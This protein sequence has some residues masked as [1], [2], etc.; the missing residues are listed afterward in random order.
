MDNTTQTLTI[1]TA[2]TVAT[3]S[4]LTIGG[5]VLTNAVIA[6]SGQATFTLTGG[7]TS[8]QTITSNAELAAAVQLLQAND[9]GAAGDSVFFTGTISGVSSTFIYTQESAGAAGAFTLIELVGVTA[10]SLITTNA[11]TAGAVFIS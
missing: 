7:A 2:A 10:T 6:A 5:A 4:V 1:A 9:I 11:T 8:A 3:D